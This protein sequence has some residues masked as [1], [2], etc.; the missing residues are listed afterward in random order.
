[1][2][3]SS[4]MSKFDKDLLKSSF[5]MAA[6]NLYGN[7]MWLQNTVN[8]ASETSRQDQENVKGALKHLKVWIRQTE[9][10]G[11]HDLEKMFSARRNACFYL[12]S[13]LASALGYSMDEESYALVHDYTL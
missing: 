9:Q 6:V 3:L 8:Y 4:A 10:N 7:L 1:M 5:H 13:M 12:E 2:S 11:E